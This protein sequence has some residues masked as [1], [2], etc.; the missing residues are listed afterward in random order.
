M[1]NKISLYIVHNK[2]QLQHHRACNTP[3]HSF[4]KRRPS[5]RL[6]LEL[7]KP[8]NTIKS[9]CTVHG[10]IG[11]Y[12]ERISTL[13]LLLDSSCQS[14]YWWFWHHDRFLCFID[15]ASSPTSISSASMMT[16]IESC[17]MSS[18]DYNAKPQYVDD[19]TLYTYTT[20]ET[21]HSLSTIK[22]QR[23]HNNLFEIKNFYTA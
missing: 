14:N 1:Q 16:P 4:S 2:L 15:V 23:Q 8:R 3:N 9:T 22:T 11:T 12:T 6:I 19:I 18:D 10:S 7:P 20:K 5:V 21:Q 17:F 13:D